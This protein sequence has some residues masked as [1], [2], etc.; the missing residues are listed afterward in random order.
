MVASPTHPRILAVVYGEE[1]SAEHIVGRLIHTKYLSVL[2]LEAV[3]NY[4]GACEAPKDD[5]SRVARAKAITDG[6]RAANRFR[7]CQHVR[8]ESE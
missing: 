5:R 1:A 4:N 2:S 3:T 6:V 7:F 8:V